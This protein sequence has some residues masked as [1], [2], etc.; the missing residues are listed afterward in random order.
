MRDML[1]SALVVLLTVV[2]SA[3]AQAP[4]GTI[5]GVVTDPVRAGVGAHVRITN[6]Q[7]G[8]A[9][10]LETST[11][12]IYTAAALVPGEYELSVEADGFKRVQ[13]MATVEAGRT[14]VADV[15]LEIG[16][17]SETVTVRGAV[18]LLQYDHHQI[19]GVVK[20]EQIENVPLNGRNVLELA[21][22]EPGV[23]S[24]VRGNANRTFIAALGAG[25]QTIPRVGFTRVTVDGASINHFG[26]I[27]TALQISP[28][29]VEE[30]EVSTANF[31]VGTSLTTNGVVNVVTRSGANE[32]RGSGFAF[33]R[34]HNLA[35][36]PALRRD[37]RNPHP[38]F[39]RG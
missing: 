37:A 10:A 18:P 1:V 9:W 38:F 34:D 6:S 30:F 26:T 31:D 2:K 15:R 39:K 21:K 36:Y 7:T 5:T 16:D 24:P 4:A 25:L 20:R 28:E 35:A 22:L 8:Q 23:T 32:Y 3:H 14:T 13:R 29:V 12:G 33:H 19:G 11:E 17:L 27:G